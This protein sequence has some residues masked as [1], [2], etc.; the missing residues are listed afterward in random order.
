M[1]IFLMWSSSYLQ[2]TATPTKIQIS[3][4][5]Y[6][7]QKKRLQTVPR[8]FEAEFQIRHLIGSAPTAVRV[9]GGELQDQDL[10]H[11]SGGRGP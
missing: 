9:R 1:V 3:D 4:E 11:G 6:N 5:K 10:R 8:R 2:Q 7:K